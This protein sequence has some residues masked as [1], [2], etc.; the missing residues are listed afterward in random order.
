MFSSRDNF[1]WF[2][3]LLAILLRWTTSRYPYSGAGKPP[4]FGDYEAQRHWME[5]TVNLSP[6]EWYKNSTANDLLYWGLDYPP[7]TAYHSYVNGLVARSINPKWIKLN[8]SRGTEGYEHKLFMRS[9]VLASDLLIY[10]PAIILYWWYNSDV[11][12]RK[13]KSIHAICAL[14]YPGLILIDHGHFQYNCISLGLTV[15]AVYFLSRNEHFLASSA[16]SL[17]LNYKQM[18]LYHALP[19]FFY[20]LSVSLHQKSSVLALRKLIAIASGVLITFGVCWA[21]YLTSSESVM[22]VLTRLFPFGRGLYEDKVANVWCSLEILV[23]LKKLFDIN[24]LVNISAL[25]TLVSVFPSGLQLLRSPSL[26]NFKYS[27]IVS[28]LCFFLF[29][30]Q[31]HEKTILIPAISALLVINHDPLYVLWFLLVST[32]SMQPLMEKDGL[33]L[34]YVALSGLFLLMFFSVYGDPGLTQVKNNFNRKLQALLFISS[35]LGYMGLFLA[36]QVIKSPKRYPDL[37]AIAFAVYSCGHFVLFLA[38]FYWR[39]FTNSSQVSAN[40]SS[41]SVKAKKKVK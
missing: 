15:W 7:L 39:Q 10:F 6:I 35:L 1:L 27:L 19:F 17:A 26:R 37:Y 16:F 29:S 31:V 5:I 4:M 3:V 9:T 38:Y 34:P 20:L 24:N 32:F 12:S 14:V 2:G 36:S 23:K 8:E 22:D 28:S 41:G 33:V 11:T 25:A 18:S 21:P 13:E 40:G 30:Y